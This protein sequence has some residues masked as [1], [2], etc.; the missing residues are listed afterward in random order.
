M[1]N[2]DF[3]WFHLVLLLLACSPISA[4]QAAEKSSEAKQQFSILQITPE[5]T[6]PK[7]RVSAEPPAD[8]ASAPTKDVATS[9]D[10]DEKINQLV[11]Q[12]VLDAIPHTYQKEKDWGA[13]ERRWDGI[14]FRREGRRIETERKWKMV[15][16]GT[17]KKYSASLINP[18]E[19]FSV[20]VRNLH[21]AAS[22]NLAFDVHFT[23]HIR[24]DARQSKWA[25]GVQ[26]YSLSA[27]GHGKVRL[28]VS[29]EMPI[30]LDVTRFPPDLIFR[31]N[32]VS[33][34]LVVDEF[35]I[36]RV[37]KLGG[38]FAQQITKAVRRTLDEKVEE[39]E[40]ELV[41]KLNSQLRKNQDDLRLSAADAIEQKWAKQAHKL[42]PSPIQKALKPDAKK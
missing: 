1:R 16:H 33:A 34:D 40:T 28:I 3:F 42:L 9:I 32:V 25:K 17:W 30:D 29:V 11:T 18:S 19:E 35:H 2:D 20:Q 41:Q 22:E 7:S 23:S 10:A 12:L 6:P 15:N 31:P 39:K 21:Q 27:E 14:R 4:Q 36:D 26:L 8:P 13:Q 5:S 24:F 37:S 38:E